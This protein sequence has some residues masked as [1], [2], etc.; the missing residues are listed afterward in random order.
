MN[1]KTHPEYYCQ[2]CGDRN[3]PWYADN[4]LWNM[5]MGGVVYT[6]ICPNCFDGRCKD[7]GVTIMFKA[8]LV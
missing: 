5:V 1:D 7:K 6:I 2:Q 8:E 4:D 3:S